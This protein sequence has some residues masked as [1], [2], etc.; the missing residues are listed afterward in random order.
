MTPEP[1]PNCG[2]VPALVTVRALFAARWI[3]PAPAA[4]ARLDQ[5]QAAHGDDALIAFCELCA[6]IGVPRYDL[7]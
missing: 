2:G 7:P 5:Y 6:F 1:C 4:I 3:V